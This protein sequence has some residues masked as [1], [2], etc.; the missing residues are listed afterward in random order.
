MH[1]AEHRDGDEVEDH[2]R[3]EQSAHPRRAVRLDREQAD[4]DADRDRHDIGPEAGLDGGQAFDRGQH[5]DRRSDHRIAVEESAGEDA[6][7][8][9]ARR[10]ALLLALRA[11][12]D[13][14]QQGEAAA[15]PFVVGAHDRHDIFEGH[16]DHHRPEDQAEDAE[17]LDRPVPERMMAGEGLAEGVDR[18]R[19]DIAEDDADRPGGEAEETRVVVPRRM[20]GGIV[21]GG[22]IAHC[23]GT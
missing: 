2:D 23:S 4:E 22:A 11:T 15:L 18:A 17:D 10:P 9:D 16:D 21:G 12:V 5:R 14:R 19:A 3:P 13:Q 20:R 1:D 7:Q 8:H 6:E